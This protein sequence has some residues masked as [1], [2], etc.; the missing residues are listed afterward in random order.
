[1]DIKLIDHIGTS[2]S[3]L[4]VDHQQWIVAVDGVQV[5]YLPKAPNSW[6]QCI[7]S[8]DEDTKAEVVEAINQ[9]IASEVGGVVMPVDPDDEPDD[10]EE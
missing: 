9:K 7:V 1:V 3:G 4:L 6:L 5:G 2:Q 8:M 10:E